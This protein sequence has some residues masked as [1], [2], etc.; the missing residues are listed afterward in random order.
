L[1]VTEFSN[2]IATSMEVENIKGN[3]LKVKTTKADVTKIKKC[4]AKKSSKA[5]FK[6]AFRISEKSMILE[7]IGN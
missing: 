3:R 7:K 4:N 2:G 1:F 6:T 5:A